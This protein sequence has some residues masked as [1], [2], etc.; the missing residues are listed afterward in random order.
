[1][2]GEEA[3]PPSSAIKSERERK[4]AKRLVSCCA[5]ACVSVAKK[6]RGCKLVE[7]VDVVELV[8]VGVRRLQK[9]CAH[10]SAQSKVQVVVGSSS[11]SSS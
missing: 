9:W 3:L 4:R 2:G 8:V 6:G 11:S 7:V 1:M 10:A 5:H